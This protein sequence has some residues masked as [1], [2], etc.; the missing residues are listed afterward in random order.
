MLHFFEPT[1]NAPRKAS[2]R[3]WLR[4][5]SIGL[6]GLALPDLLNPQLHARGKVRSKAKSVIIFGLLGGP[7][8]HD[9]W[10]PKPDAPAE[11]RG[12]FGTIATRTPGLRVGELM[13]ETAKLT[14]KIAVL[15]AM[16]TN[17]NAHSSSG[18]QMLTGVPH[19]PLNM[20]SAAPKA[21]NN[22]PS[23]GAIVRYLRPS[24]GQL[25]SAIT[26]PEH[27]WNDGNFPWPGQDAGLL[28]RQHHPWLIACDPSN[29]K[30]H[31]DALDTPKDIP[32]A[33]VEDRRGLLGQ[34]NHRIGSSEDGAF[35]TYDANVRRALDL[36]CS[37]AARSA[38][39]LSRESDRVRDRYGHRRDSRRTGVRHDRQASR[40]SGSESRRA[41]A[42]CPDG[43]SRDG[44]RRPPFDR[45]RGP[46]IPPD[47]RRPRPP[48]TVLTSHSIR[49]ST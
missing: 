33:R 44:N 36:V 29:A 49:K 6:G 10:D 21:P 7:P 31:I 41:R 34:M 42:Y 40:V 8:Q 46:S 9:T 12:A 23:L 20:E 39:D 35:E 3:E 48:R 43:A 15:R 32:I 30:F 2:R 4:V 38:F 5:G 22:W 37:G 47:G 11:I 45:P 1:D 13:P 28:G 16:V 14:D 19:Q 17:D 24:A 27:I 18:Y 25:P 26:V